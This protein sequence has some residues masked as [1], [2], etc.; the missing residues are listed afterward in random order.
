[1][2]SLFG[3]CNFIETL[4]EIGNNNNLIYNTFLLARRVASSGYCF[5][6]VA[7]WLS[8]TRRHCV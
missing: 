4:I 2:S 1:M 8:V 3:D 6:N 7:G 5:R